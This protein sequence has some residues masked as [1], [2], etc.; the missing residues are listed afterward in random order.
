[1][2]ASRRQ[3]AATRTVDA[4]APAIADYALIGNGRSAALVGKNGGIDWLCSPRFDS[5]AVFGALLDRARG[6]TF[7]VRPAIPFSVTRRYLPETNV[8][9]TTFHTASGRA[10]VIDLMPVFTDADERQR[11]IPSASVLRCVQG[12]A[13]EV[14]IAI[15]YAPRFDY[16]RVRPRLRRRG[17]LGVFCAH[18]GSALLLQSSTPLTLDGP[19]AQG[20]LTLRPGESHALLLT[21]ADREPLALPPLADAPDLLE[22]TVRFWRTWV[23]QCNYDGPYRDAVLRSLLVLKLLAYSPSGAIVAAPTTSLPEQPGGERNWDYRYCWLRD[24]SM[25]LRAL[26][27][28]GYFQEGERFLGWML[29]STRLTSPQLKVLYDVYGET[30]LTERELS[31]LRGYGG[32]RPV[33]VGNSAQDQLQLDVYGQVLDAVFEYVCHGRRRLDRAAARMLAGLGDTVCRRW[34]EPDNGIWETRGSRR[35][36]TFSKVLCWVALDRLIRLHDMGAIKI[37][38]A[39]FAAAQAAIVRAVETEGYSER[40]VSY[41]SAFGAEEVDGSLLLLPYYGYGPSIE[42]TR[43][44]YYRLRERLGVDELFYR[45]RPDY[46]DGLPPGEGTFAACAFWAV[47]CRALHGEVS[48]ARADFERLLARAND[49][50]LYG[51]EI[52][53]ASGA[54]LGNFPQAYTH[55]SLINAALS[56]SRPTRGVESGSS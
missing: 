27:S 16:G 20:R 9:E 50:G 22:R 51:E 23:A 36:Y 25:T 21:Y 26:F 45:Y 11:F 1:M 10:R 47:E 56:L 40:L 30:R 48:A 2:T 52:D 35:H 31:Y 4:T 8:L 42:R 54:T 6:G 34:R 29:H 7:A 55:V 17:A 44:T 38:R 39:R 19:A 18:R 13:G 41:V 32:A 24:A 5:P 3:P 43:R 33:R 37:S 12:I 15:E 49:V 53:A 28:L 46:D 14:P